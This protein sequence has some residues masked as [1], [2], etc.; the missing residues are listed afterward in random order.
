MSVAEDRLVA[1][2]VMAEFQMACGNEVD[3]PEA[4]V[5]C[6]L[7]RGWLEPVLSEPDEDGEV[8]GQLHLSDKAR[9]QA[10][11]WSPEFGVDLSFEPEP[12]E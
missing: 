6:L 10:D 2:L 5:A 7:D 9:A 3:L 8:E 1:W 12:S 4:V 11:L